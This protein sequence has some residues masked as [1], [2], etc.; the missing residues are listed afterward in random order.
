MLVP[1]DS[2]RAFLEESSK[3][4]HNQLNQ[5]VVEYL[6]GPER[7]LDEETIRRFRLGVVVDPQPGH[8]NYV[9][10]LTIPYLTPSGSV[11]SI[12]FR[13]LPPAEKIYLT[14]PGDIT[15]I[16]NTS[17]LERGT[18]SICVTEGE[19]DCWVAEMCGLP[20]IGIPG[21]QN[22][23]PMWADLLEP[24]EFVFVLSDDDEPGKELPKTMGRNLR[25]IRDVPMVCS[26]KKGDVTSFFLE[27]GAEELRRKVGVK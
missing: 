1:S 17:A 3:E 27:H 18:R 9:G 23:N 6:T 4:Y 22:W 14:A 12:R 19:P 21:T 13:S 11:I 16:Y 5:S 8:E 7:G 15:R 24:Y 20:A 10:C 26:Q 2:L 25:N